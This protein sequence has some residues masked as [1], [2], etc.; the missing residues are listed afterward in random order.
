MRDYFQLDHNLLTSI[1][2][3]ISRTTASWFCP[4]KPSPPS[5]HPSFVVVL[6]LHLHLMQMVL[7]CRAV[8]AH[9]LSRFRHWLFFEVL[10]C[11]WLPVVEC[12]NA[13][14][15]P[16]ELKGTGVSSDAHLTHL[17]NKM[18]PGASW[19]QRMAK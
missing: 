2:L 1:T 17:S 4:G 18:F 8:V 7:Y 19:E 5:R 11:G 6:V 9:V 13:E 15:T 16:T 3:S 10:P 12:Q 14:L